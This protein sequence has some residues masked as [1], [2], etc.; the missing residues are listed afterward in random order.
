MTAPLPKMRTVLV[1]SEKGSRLSLPSTAR[2]P[3]TVT[4][5]SSATGCCLMAVSPGKVVVDAGR[6]AVCGLAVEILFSL[7]VGGI[8]CTLAKED[9]LSRPVPDRV[10]LEHLYVPPHRRAPTIVRAYY[11]GNTCTRGQAKISLRARHCERRFETSAE[12]KKKVV[13][14]IAEEGAGSA[15]RPRP[16]S[17]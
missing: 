17:R 16:D 13:K 9:F 5:T 15:G 11:S 3:L 14:V 6:C 2:A 10:S 1:V 4:G 12:R 7:T 8:A